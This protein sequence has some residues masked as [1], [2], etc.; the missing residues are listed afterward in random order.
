MGKLSSGVEAVLALYVYEV[1]RYRDA[2]KGT[3]STTEHKMTVVGAEIPE[4]RG[5]VGSLTVQPRSGYRL[6]DSVE[7]ALEED[8]KRI[9]VESAEFDR[10]YEVFVGVRDDENKARQILS[11]AFLVWL[12]EQSWDATFGSSTRTSC[13]HV[14]GTRPMPA[15]STRSASGRARS[16]S[17]FVRRRWRP[18]R[19][20]SPSASSNSRARTGRSPAR[21]QT[22]GLGRRRRLPP[23][24][25]GG[26]P[27]GPAAAVRS[28]RLRL[29]CA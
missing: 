18:S 10:R 15:S 8:R 17:G 4:L 11:P 28:G 2:Q 13:S 19:R 16:R 6:F 27:G 14:G 3:E 21:R 26:D 5:L 25:R 22:G 24:A 12:T 9:E 7:D 29:R 23:R 20:P 1:L